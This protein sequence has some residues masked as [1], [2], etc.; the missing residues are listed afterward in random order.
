MKKLKSIVVVDVGASSVKMAEFSSATGALELMKYGVASLGEQSS[1]GR[2]AAVMSAMRE[3]MLEHGISKG[4]AII[5]VPGQSVFTKFVK[6]PPVAKE[7]LQQIV[8]YEAVQ[9]VPF[10]ID[11]VVWDYHALSRDADEVSVMLV[12]IK[13]DLIEGLMHAVEM[14]G[15]SPKSVDVAPV[16]LFNAVNYNY[17]DGDGCSLV[18]DVGARSTE[19]I[20]IENGRVF[21]RSIPVAGNALTQQIMRESSMSFADAE[22]LMV[23]V[24]RGDA[25]V[26]PTHA[27]MV[28]SC[29]KNILMRLNGEIARS[30]SFYKS[31][32][33]GEAPKHVFLAGGSCN[34]FGL[35][36]ALSEKLGVQVENLDLFNKVKVSPALDRAL[37]DRSRAQLGELVGL[38]LRAT[39]ESAVE[40]DLMPQRL[41]QQRAFKKRQP[42][43][44]ATCLLIALTVGVWGAHSATTLSLARQELDGVKTRVDAL[45]KLE[46]PLERIEAETD[47]L[48]RYADHFL[49]LSRDRAHWLHV[50][51][52]IRENTADGIV[53]SGLD[54]MKDADGRV[55]GLSLSGFAY[56][57]KVEQR[58]AVQKYWK[59]LSDLSIFSVK[60]KIVKQPSA[61][62]FSQ[63]FVIELVFEEPVDA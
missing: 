60:S 26:A 50:L 25:S 16:A 62:A 37:F 5:A 49:E 15:I 51:G 1:D 47:R 21:M 3:L 58:T 38:A 61:N 43:L 7:K 48:T 13:S 8:Q 18:V 11:E 9:N 53:I 24:E 42:A 6:C 35:K 30:V 10:P 23:Q 29:T 57:D 44:V 54:P 32:Q 52:A 4:S 31:Q 28:K 55:T 12:A 40:V 34:M 39:G 27:E 59:R 63:E 56:L 17:S 45:Q 19:L 22:A 46:R 36:A 33:N 41:L 2:D 14:A 20:F